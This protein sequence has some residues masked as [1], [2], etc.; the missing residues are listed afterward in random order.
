MRCERVHVL[1]QRL[2]HL[3]AA[4][5]DAV[6]LGGGQLQQNAVRLGL[7]PLAAFHEAFPHLRILPHLRGGGVSG[8][9]A[10]RSL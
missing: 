7:G 6:Q 1:Q 5:E 2:S 8:G 3:R 4:F 9:R 10:Q